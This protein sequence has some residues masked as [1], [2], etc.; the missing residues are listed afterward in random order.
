MTIGR[1]VDEGWDGL[2]RDLGFDPQQDTE[3]MHLLRAIGNPDTSP[4]GWE[5]RPLWEEAFASFTSE[6]VIEILERNGAG[7]CPMT[8]YPNVFEL[9]QVKLLNVLREVKLKSGEP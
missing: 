2:F 6:Q 3:R 4:R 8:D 1:L 9:P 5:S 7:G